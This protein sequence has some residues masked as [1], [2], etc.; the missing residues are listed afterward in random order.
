MHHVC[1][2]I[3]EI[4]LIENRLVVFEDY[5]I[6]QAAPPPGLQVLFVLNFDLNL[7]VIGQGSVN[8]QEFL[9]FAVK[10]VAM[11]LPPSMACIA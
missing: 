1:S 11:T 2:G 3:P 5:V 4:R 7:I 9:P 10:T 6:Y 8:I